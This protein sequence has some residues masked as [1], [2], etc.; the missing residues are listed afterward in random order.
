MKKVA[1]I[2]GGTRGIGLGISTAFLQQGYRVALCYGSDTHNAKLALNTLN[3]KDAMIIQADVSHPDDRELILDKTNDAWGG[4]D[5][6]VN[7]AGIIRTGQFL[8]IQPE[9]FETVMNTNFYGPLYLSQ[10]F[11]NQLIQDKKDSC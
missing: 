8:E 3:T 4:F 11:A 6:L 10:L 2:T 7:N 1:I 5:V 9:D